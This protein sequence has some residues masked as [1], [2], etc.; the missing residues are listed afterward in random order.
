MQKEFPCLLLH[1]FILCL[2]VGCLCSCES[3][4]EEDTANQ[5]HSEAIT[6]L[7]EAIAYEM[8]DKE[9]PAVSIVLVDDQQTAWAEAF[10]MENPAQ[11][12]AADL[13]TV[14]R[15]G[16]VS[17]LFTDIAIMQLVEQGKVD[18][19]API[20]TYL[21]SFKPNNP[22]DTPITLRQLMSHRSGLI[23][24]PAVGHYFDDTTPS[25]AQTVASLS[26]VPLIY[27]PETKTKY[28]NAGIAVV[29]YVLETM[30]NQAF[31]DYLEEHILNPIGLTS[32]SF[33]LSA[34][35]KDQLA[36]GEMWSYDGRRFPAPGFEL[37]MAPAGSM[38]ATIPGCSVR[39]R[40]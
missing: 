2:S 17:K 26:G 18:L 14:Y 28:S 24:E 37:G 11:N 40:A 16:S 19:D 29:G 8:E 21:R 4:P 9:L 32:S 5:P 31:P 36:T 22:Y 35:V 12:K 6:K 27:E 1:L 30:Q 38:Y 20:Q 15:I 10:G 23:R 25:L 13:N 34:E 3:A 39:S 7:K 33:Q